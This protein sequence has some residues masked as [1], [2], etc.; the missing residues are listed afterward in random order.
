MEETEAGLLGYLSIIRDPRLERKKLHQVGDILFISVC[1]SLCGC[2]TWE[3][4]HLFATTREAW[5]LQYIKLENGIPSPDT[6]AR[7]FSLIDPNEFENAFRQ[8]VR[9]HYMRMSNYFWRQKGQ[10]NLKRQRMI[11]MKRLKK[12]MGG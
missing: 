5:F 4:I 7:V 11:I 10:M 2:D 1:A 3:D 6:I 12:G 9:V 8:W